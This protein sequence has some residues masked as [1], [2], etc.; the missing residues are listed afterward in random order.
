MTV[1]ADRE[2]QAEKAYRALKKLILDNEIPPGSHLLEQEAGLRLGM[3]RTP[4]REAMVRLQQEGMVE[5][6]P[7]HGMRV[8]PIS[9]GDMAEIYDILTVLEALAARRAAEQGVTTE[10]LAQLEAAVRDMDLA[11][12]QD[13][14][15]AWAE[16]DMRFHALLVAASGSRR[17]QNAVGNVVDQS[18]RARHLTLH[19]RP[20]PLASNEDHRAVV[21][22][23]K[24]RDADRAHDIHF[25]H[26]ERNG[27]Q[28]IALLTRL[29]MPA[30]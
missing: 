15:E 4:V 16:A 21:E 13:N 25:Q 17:L 27:R 3:S 22:A 23:I 9:L 28:L 1:Q 7:R 26:R 2:P 29:R 11:L 24:A 10:A 6:R 19:L 5:I 14:R 8:L 20:K 30:L 12:D 18:S